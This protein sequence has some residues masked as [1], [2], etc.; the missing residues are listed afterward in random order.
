MI[1]N[2]S[3]KFQTITR[4]IVY[5]SIFFTFIWQIQNNIKNFQNNKVI[6]EFSTEK[7]SNP[8]FPKISLCPEYMFNPIK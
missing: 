2:M 3:N 5:S 4:V 6:T 8:L 7:L 1:F